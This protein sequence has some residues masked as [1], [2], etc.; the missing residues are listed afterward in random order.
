M[1]RRANRRDEEAKAAPPPEGTWAARAEHGFG[2]AAAWVARPAVLNTLLALVV[3]AGVLVRLP[4]AMDESGYFRHHSDEATYFNKAYAEYARDG[5][6]SGDRLP[7]AHGGSGLSLFLEQVFRLAGIE[8]GATVPQNPPPGYTFAPEQLEAARLAYLTNALVGASVV[9][10]T[11]L[12]CR[13][14]LPPLA[15]LAGAAFAAFDP[16]LV[17][18]SGQLMTEPAY[19]LMLTL[20][21]AAVLKAREHPAWLLAVGPLMA[22]AHMLRVNGLVMLFMVVLF[23]VL[24]FRR[25][26]KVPWKH[27]ALTVGLFFLVAAPYLIWR[28]DHLPGAFDYGTN[29]RFF[30]DDPWDFSDE[31]WQGYSYSEGGPRETAGDYLGSHSLGTAFRR[32]WSSVLLQVV[33][34]VG[35]G[36]S[37]WTRLDAPAFHPLLV[38][39]CAVG[40]VRLRGRPEHWALPIAL[41]FSFLTFVWV[42]PIVR[43]PRYFMPLVPLAI[44]YGLA[45]ARSLGR[46]SSR[47]WT[48]CAVLVGLLLAVFAV[49]P[50]FEGLASL[51]RIADFGL[52]GITVASS[53]LLAALALAP[54]ATDLV[55]GRAAPPPAAP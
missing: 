4:G 45:G 49:V 14:L 17:R 34:L 9:V 35:A 8:P 41:A 46:T 47:P 54:F 53:L 26:S 15:V 42:Y 7:L 51:A 13:Q 10:A 48:L 24:L 40:A 30:A 28:A 19:T 38:V 32:L 1:R 44:A 52:L 12:L 20:A 11:V 31:Y 27:V 23:G 39:L 3:V 21:V 29:Q 2:R 55:R 37:P 43:S 22:F 50:A 16:A 25:E 33:D 18:M 5:A 36:S 6:G